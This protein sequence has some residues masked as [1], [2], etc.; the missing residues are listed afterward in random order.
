MSAV[1]GNADDA[2]RAIKLGDATG[3]PATSVFND[4]DG[5]EKEYRAGLTDQIVRGNSQLDTYINSHPLAAT[6]SN[7]DW[8]NLDQIS[9]KATQSSGLLDFLNAPWK[10]AD[11]AVRAGIEGGVQGFKEGFAGAQPEGVDKAVSPRQNILG[12]V[13]ALASTAMYGTLGLMGGVFGGTVGAAKGAATSVGGEQFGRDIGAM[14]EYE[15]IKGDQAWHAAGKEPPRGVDPKIDAAKAQLNAHTLDQ[16][17]QIYA[18]AQSQST[19]LARSPEM[20][21]QFMEQHYAGQNISIGGDAV[22][23]LYGDKLPVAGDGLLGFVDGI[24]DKVALARSTGADVDVPISDWITHVDPKVATAL[25]DDVRMWPGGVTAREATEAVEPKAMVDGPLPQVRGAAGLEPMFAMGDRKLQLTMTKQ[26]APDPFA[27][28]WSMDSKLDEYQILDEKGAP[29]GQMRIGRGDNRELLVD[30]VGGQAGLWANSFGPS[31]IRDLKRQ[32][33]TLYPDY[34]YLTGYRISGAR[35]AANA[36]DELRVP[37]VRLDTN[38][39]STAGDDAFRQH[40]AGAWSEVPGQPGMWVNHGPSPLLAAKWMDLAAAVHG[41]IDKIT[42]GHADIRSSFGLQADEHP[43][44][45]ISGMYLPFQDR[46]PIIYHDLLGPDPIGTGRHESIHMLRRNNFFSPEEWETLE[47]AAYQEDWQGRYQIDSR[48][49]HQPESVRTEEAVA[50]AFREWA[51]SGRPVGSNTAGIFQKL[52]DFLQKVKARIGD[53]FGRQPTWEELFQKT[54]SGEVGQRGPGAP[55]DGAFDMRPQFSIDDMDGLKA[56]AT[57][58]DLKS[59]QAIQKLMHERYAEDL[60]AA[61]NRAAKDQAQRQSK[62]WRENRADMMK[63]VDQSIRQRPDVAADLFLGSGEFQGKKL[64]QRFTLRAEDLTPEQRMALPDHYVSKNGLPPDEVGRLFGYP[65]GDMMVERLAALQQLKGDLSPQ[66]AVKKI[67]EAE[68]DRQMQA[69]Y[70]DRGENVMTAARDQALSDTNLNILAEEMH[71]AG[72]RAGTG[73]IDKNAAKAEAQASFEKMPVGSVNA[74]K[75]MELVGKHGRDAERGLI[76]GDAAGALVSLQRKFMSALLAREASDFEKEQAKF[77]KVAKRYAKPYDPTK[78]KARDAD[79]S[80]FTR[81]ILGRLGQKNGMS[82]AWMEKAIGESGFRDL[83][84][85]VTKTEKQNELSGLE[86]PVPDFL[87]D[88]KFQK[89]LDQLTVGEGRAAM[90]AVR[91][92]DKIGKDTAKVIREGKTQELS[93]FVDAARTQLQDKFQPVTKSERDKSTPV[94]AVNALVAASTNNETLMSRFDGRD[95]HG[96]FTENITYPAAE[97][98]NYEARLQRETAGKMKDLGKL[99]DPKKLVSSPFVNPQTKIPLQFKRENLAA[100]IS[101][102]GNNYNW[103]IL[104]K[105]W[106]LDPEM[107]WKWVEANTKPED[108]IRAQKMG[109]IFKGLKRESD[110]VYQHLYGVAPE[111]IV[112]RPFQMHGQSFE[113]WYHPIIGDSELSAFVNK[114]DLPKQNN[115]WPSTSN[116]YVKR[117]TGAVQVLDLTYDSIPA[118][119]GQVIHDIAFREPVSNIAKIFKDRGFRQGVTQYYGKVYLDEMD[120]W[121]NRIAGQ[122]SYQPEV[123]RLANKI[124][125]NLRQNVITTQIAF[126]VGTME[127]HG[128]TA[129]AMSAR[130]LDYNLFKS[131]PLMTYLT[132]KNMVVH[133][134]NAVGDLFGKSNM[135]GEDMWNFVKENSEEIQRRERNYQDTMMGQQDILSGNTSIRKL[136]SQYG[137]KLVAWSDMVSAIPL[138]LAK[139]REEMESNGGIHGDA[140]RVA[141]SAVRRAHGSTAVTNL[142][143]IATGNNPMTP[144]MTSLYGFMGTSMQRRLEMVHDV[145][146]MFSLGMRGDINGAAAKVPQI[147]ASFA[148]YVVWTGVVEEAVTSQFTDDRRGL[149]Q[150]A[151]TFA[152]GTAA[153][154]IIGLRDLV[155]DL[156]TGS[157]S[158]GLISTPIH[159]IINFKRDISK[160]DPSS[161]EHAGK[162]VQDTITAIGDLTGVGPKHIGTVARYGIDAFSGFAKPKDAGDVYHGLMSGSQKL[163]VVK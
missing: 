158:G 113:G 49:A 11:D 114:L 23:A 148:V 133:Y 37:R 9:Q 89:P 41:E 65:S 59:F 68:T 120:G 150:R 63:E 29:V 128:P 33:K 4:L 147:L 124:S 61:T 91:A 134:G 146:D 139:Y 151:L 127:K 162:L 141:D 32:L 26:G 5:A 90:N 118:R 22:A 21:H 42:G 69:K 83:G 84:D 44:Q 53:V 77:Q 39:I 160:S 19:T 58:L 40:L 18:A 138:W 13:G 108:I 47:N 93:E 71:A 109:D 110:L 107:L 48:Y 38:D 75:M 116:S 35:D 101:N 76:G 51:A 149:G 62:E 132:G 88:P 17:E 30:W 12:P 154:T 34:D 103:S 85:F 8:G 27:D 156:E 102:M 119:M 78:D 157:D 123:L 125:D 70:G 81:D 7:D 2:A 6:V 129:L 143:R 135:L 28:T 24:A 100:V 94:R 72:L 10:V 122:D 43:N 163:R 112:P 152:F 79:F 45:R 96:L 136:V 36:P 1:D 74:D 155:H 14:T 92:L 121:L 97:A 87:L 46:A 159:D 55:M 57:G 130:E 153:Q 52:W 98:A 137:A 31:L 15:M 145:N 80:V 25:H 66:A 86:L 144:W 50:E 60:E 111:N 56:S 20:F 95:P 106:N 140:V 126:N 3:V 16:L 117:R 64:Q 142:P 161:K 115:F 73:V 67:V 104:A 82:P 54:A 99:E 105:G 131:V